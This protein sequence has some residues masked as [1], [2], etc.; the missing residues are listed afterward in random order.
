MTSVPVIPSLSPFLSSSWFLKQSR[1]FDAN[2]CR[3]RKSQFGSRVKYIL[4]IGP[5]GGP[6]FALVVYEFVLDG[7]V[8][9][10]PAKSH[11][12]SHASADLS[13]NY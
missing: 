9:C 3:K 11:N 12:S 7:H 5:G 1:D 4:L 2:F 8:L 10:P 6:L 13:K